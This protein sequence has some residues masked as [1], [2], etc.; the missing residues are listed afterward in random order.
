MPAYP[1]L[2][3]YP[4]APCKSRCLGSAHPVRYPTQ[5]TIRYGSL[6]ARPLTRPPGSPSLGRLAAPFAL[7]AGGSRDP[8]SWSVAAMTIDAGWRVLNAY[9]KPRSHNETELQCPCSARFGSP[10]SVPANERS[11]MLSIHQKT[12]RM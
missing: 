4:G 7:L 6:L 5:R 8:P 2:R 11:I 1:H 12:F 3:R 9:K 10:G